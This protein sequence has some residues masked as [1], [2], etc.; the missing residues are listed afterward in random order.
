[1]PSL[2]LIF[3]QL[4]EEDFRVLRAMEKLSKR[5]E[6]APLE[7]IVRE[8]GLFEEKTS[9]I[10][11][12]LYKLKLVKSRLTGSS[13]SYRLTY[14]GLDMLALKGL[15]DHNVISAIGERIGVGKESELYKALSPQGDLLAVKFIRLGRQS[16]RR[17][18]IVR[19][20]AELPVSSWFDQSKVAAEREYKALVELHALKAG[21]PKPYG[22]N[23]H[24]TVIQYIDGVEL[25]R[26]PM[27]KRPEDA[28]QQI[29]DTIR[30]AYVNAGIIHGDLS[31]YNIIVEKE[32]EKPYIIDWPQYIYKD[33]VN[34]LELLRR[35][36][37]YILNFFMKVY[38]VSKPLEEA[39]KYVTS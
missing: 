8:S 16:F 34:A 5:Y 32:S 39:L 20:W 33:E 3:K 13:R 6:Y 2:G 15:V 26:R 27:L 22:F 12:K 9:L 38:R 30:I 29:L 14:L 19:S 21:V 7:A 23:R 11:S 10:L 37:K 17:T 31:E 35:D 24:A 4:A 25:Y 1:M 28:L 36:L 18:R